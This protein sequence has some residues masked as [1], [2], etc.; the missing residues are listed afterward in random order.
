[1]LVYDDD[2]INFACHETNWVIDS[3]A[4]VH[5]TSWE[6]F[7]TSYTRGDFGSVKMGN[8]NM[9][10]VI[11]FGDVILETDSGSRLVLKNVK[12]VPDIRVNIISTRKLDDEG[13]CNVFSN[14]Q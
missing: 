9:A 1:M 6:N 8:N 4:F 5:A 12:H 11:G 2:S 7:F 13:Y 10:K 14:G 3:E